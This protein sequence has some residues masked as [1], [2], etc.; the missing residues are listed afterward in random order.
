PGVRR[1]FAL[2]IGQRA[3]ARL[4]T[5]AEP[6]LPEG[7][8]EFVAER[9]PPGWAPELIALP[10]PPL[11]GNG[12]IDH[13]ALVRRAETVTATAIPETDEPIRPGLETRIAHLWQDVLGGDRPDRTTNFFGA[14]GDSLSATRLVGRLARELGLTVRLRRFFLDP[15]IA[16][17]ARTRIDTDLAEPSEQPPLAPTA[18]ALTADPAHRHDPFPL[19]DIQVAYW[20]GRSADFDLG[21]IGAQL[22][23]EY[24]WP[25]LDVERLQASWN[26][27]I[28]RHAM[29]RTVIDADGRQRVLPGTP[30]YRIQVVETG[31]DFDSAA[32]SMRDDMASGALDAATGPLFAVRVL[33]DVDRARLCVA[34]DS[35][36]IDGLSALVVISD[37]FRWYADPT[38]T[39][40]PLAVEFRDYVLGCAPSDS[41]VAAGLAYW[42]ERLAELPPGPQLPLRMLPAMIERPRFTRREVWLDPDVWQG[43]VR[44]ARGL[45]V[46]PSVVLLACYTG[47]LGAWS[48]QRELTVTL[49]R[50]DRRDVHPDI[51][52]V[53]GDFS[54]LLLVADR[55]EAHESWAGRARRLQEQLWS[56]LDHQQVS[57]VR[58]LRELGRESEL[59]AEP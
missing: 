33:R 54:S 53:V 43:I 15:T 26:R 31:G 23:F 27:V 35:L 13:A 30:E 19:T 45:G 22:Y 17:L 5:F 8:A 50:F 20:L 40:E 55:P 38:V 44:R 39:S 21:G 6:G 14:G 42:R 1:A 7:L 56:D 2:A 47:V 57:A 51:M 12:K 9:I 59:A 58:V 29:L 49:T 3:S 25:G 16:G 28:Q 4:V 52:R 48:A 41:E 10:D 46:T 11:T 37:W 18:P 32:A 36:V 24:D 34:F